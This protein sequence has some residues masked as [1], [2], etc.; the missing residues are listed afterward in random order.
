MKLLRLTHTGLM[1]SPPNRRSVLI[2]DID[3]EN[4][5]KAG[6]PRRPATKQ[7]AYVPVVNPYDDNQAGFIDLVISDRVQASYEAGQIKKAIDEGWL[8]ATI[9]DDSA[10][11]PPSV[12]NVQYNPPT[13]NGELQIDGAG[14]D[15]VAPD[16]TAVLIAAEVQGPPIEIQLSEWEIT[17][18]PY[19]GT[20][21]PAQIKFTVP[22]TSTLG[23]LLRSPQTLYVAVYS[24]KQLSNEFVYNHP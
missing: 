16:I 21:L 8:S 17:H 24:D 22:F 2:P 19:S 7:P 20:I 11:T 1:T 9:F 4:A 14:F 10:L 15:S 18:A 5:E 3:L 6:I 13:I 23:Q 12:T